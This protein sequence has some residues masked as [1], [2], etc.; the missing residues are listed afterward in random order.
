MHE[1]VKRTSQIDLWID[2][3]IVINEGEIVSLVK[4]NVLHIDIKYQFNMTIQVEDQVICAEP[5]IFGKDQTTVVISCTG[6]I[7]SQ[8]RI[9][10]SNNT[11]PELCNNATVK[12]NVADPSQHY[13]SYS[14]TDY[15]SLTDSRVRGD[16]TEGLQAA[17]AVIDYNYEVAFDMVPFSPEYHS[18]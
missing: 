17:R 3:P 16:V 4:S 7:I 5:V 8:M 14:E 9:Q 12:L 1:I 15:S 6:P 2:F 13:Y 10:Q 11:C 18:D